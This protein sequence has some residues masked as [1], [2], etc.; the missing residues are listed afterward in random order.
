MKRDVSYGS[1]LQIRMT[2]TF[3]ILVDATNYKLVLYIFGVEDLT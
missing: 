2:H 3:F 1:S